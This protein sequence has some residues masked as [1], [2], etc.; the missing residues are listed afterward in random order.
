MYLVK[1]KNAADSG[2]K[3]IYD[4]SDKALCLI[5]QPKHDREMNQPGSFD[6]TI[7]TDSDFYDTIV[8]MDTFISAFEGTDAEHLE[9]TFYGRVLTCED[10]FYGTKNV[11]CEGVLS[12][13]K[14]ATVGHVSTDEHNSGREY[15][16]SPQAFLQEHL[17]AYNAKVEERKKIFYG[18][19]SGITSSNAELFKID[20]DQDFKSLLENQLIDVFGGF[21]KI[22]RRQNGTHEL[23]YVKNYGINVGTA[24]AIQ[25]GQNILDKQKHM[26]GE[27]V[28]TF[29]RPVGKDS[30]RLDDGVYHGVSCNS[31]NGRSGLYPVG[32]DAASFNALYARYGFI[33][34]AKSF[35]DCETSAALANSCAKYVRD[36][37]LDTLD[38][39]PMT[40]D[41]KLVDFFNANP[42]VKRIELGMNYILT[43]D[44][45]GRETGFEGHSDGTPA[46]EGQE[47]LTLTV[48]SM[49][50]EYE[51]PE[52]DSATF[53]NATY[54]TA[55]DYSIILSS[56]TGSYSGSYGGGGSRGGLSGLMSS[57]EANMREEQAE[58]GR[59]VEKRFIDDE[60]SIGM[61]VTITENGK[62]IN[63]GGIWTEITGTDKTLLQG[64]LDVD[65]VA[66]RSGAVITAIN[67]NEGDGTSLTI[68]FDRLN[69]T[70]GALINVING[71]DPS[72][73]GALTINASKL[74]LGAAGN[75]YLSVGQDGSLNLTADNAV[76]AINAATA[77]VNADHISVSGTSLTSSIDVD[78]N[79]Q[80]N[81]KRL[82]QFGDGSSGYVTI[83]GGKVS[84]RTLQGQSLTLTGSAGGQTLYTTIDR[85]N[86]M[87]L[88]TGFGNSTESSGQINIPFYTVNSG[89]QPAGN[90]NFN[91]AATQFYIDG[92][93]ARTAHSISEITLGSSDIGESSQ[94]V[95]VF[96]TDDWE[97]DL[98]VAVDASAVYQVGQWDGWDDASSKTVAPGAIESGIEVTSF[99]FKA[100]TTTTNQDGTKTRAQTDF[101][102]TLSKGSTPSSSGYASVATGG[103]T[104]G[105]IDIGDWYTAG[106]NSVTISNSDIVRDGD[107]YYNP[108]THGT[109]IYIEA[110]ASNGAQGTQSFIVP[111]DDAYDAGYTAGR[112]DGYDSGYNNGYN[113]GR[114][115]GYN[116][117][118][119]NGYSAGNNDGY[120]TGYN[121]AVGNVRLMWW[122]GS[123]W[124]DLDTT[125]DYPHELA[126]NST[127]TVA[128]VYVNYQGEDI[129]SHQRAIHAQ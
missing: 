91:I 29:I 112:N 90:I 58:E 49:H 34:K 100:P 84:A 48:Y 57:S 118:Y 56:M 120:V 6:F 70:D 111:G 54:L 46:Q 126:H 110:T 32:T 76:A 97:E 109:I 45:E 25:I 69:I 114:N 43:V 124:Y 73:P 87:S 22:N 42:N 75:S 2:W 50:R 8:P 38:K 41:V 79:G 66:L 125:F 80:L 9:E 44:S 68:D 105:R 18:G 108:N 106:R 127:M 10:D 82:T 37:G 81:I 33:E 60:D 7:Y 64:T 51:N 59:K 93:A 36:Y 101:N 14:D 40:F 78:Q 16:T 61:V 15:R 28:F 117:G 12:F 21:F 86:L 89:G 23:W 52:N 39:L 19:V 119:N 74:K 30:V 31:S 17:T 27:G 11:S 99:T 104:V 88:V 96:S 62:V 24:Q 65:L 92:V 3:T 103:R 122:D 55:K 113:I 123:A 85:A 121:N 63:A 1:A 115:D 53:Y 20:D 13:L 72:T 35:E 26:T 95:T 5:S 4:S 67:N 77:M 98:S 47:G 71:D 94:P 102:F 129:Y 128:A 107:D 83:N 116:N